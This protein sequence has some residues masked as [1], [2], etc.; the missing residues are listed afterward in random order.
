MFHMLVPGLGWRTKYM[1]EGDFRLSGL[2]L[3]DHGVVGLHGWS[4]LSRMRSH[5]LRREVRAIIYKPYYK[6]RILG[7]G[8][9]RVAFFFRSF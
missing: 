2:Y 7:F 9:R 8:I 4:R 1:Y 5:S 3:Y 6:L